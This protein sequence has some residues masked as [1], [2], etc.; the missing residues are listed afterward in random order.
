MK[1]VRPLLFACLA[2][3]AGTTLAAPAPLSPSDVPFFAKPGPWGRLR[4]V[5]VYLEAAD[6]VVAAFGAPSARTRW[7][8][9]AA[10]ASNLPAL[11]ERCGVESNLAVTLGQPENY[12]IEEPYVHF[13]PPV[14]DLLRIKPEARARLYAELARHPANE[15]QV[16]P[17]F[18]L[19]ESIDDWYRDSPL[20]PELVDKIKQLAYRR[21]Q[22]W[23]FSDLSALVHFCRSEN[24]VRLAIK[25]LTRTRGLCVSLELTEKSDITGLLTYWGAASPG[26]RK[27]IE[28][29]VRTLARTG[30]TESLDLVHLLPALPRKLLFTYPHPQM[31]R[32]GIYPDCHWTSLNFFNY[33]PRDHLAD[34]RQ[35]T[36][37]L[38][39]AYEFVDP[40]FQFGDVLLL[41]KRDSS[42]VIHSCV[43][44]ADDLVFTKNGRNITA[45]WLIMRLDFVRRLYETESPL[46]IRA[47][48]LRGGPQ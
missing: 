5:P 31:A 9:D 17:A 14:A 27:D 10:Q 3:A 13:F 33:S 32:A 15:L 29:L 43:Y 38:S 4:C 35:G 34:P 7:T 22:T 48:R 30:S 23:A 6:S 18:I 36:A 41:T 42:D 40:P 20:P 21:G 11:L 24:E 47:C 1:F 25:A 2:L 45:P 8:L 37:L 16:N 12:L 26:R 19:T 28:P 44:L 46:T 39:D